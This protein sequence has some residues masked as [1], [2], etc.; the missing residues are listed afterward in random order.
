MA[1][2]EFARETRLVT[3]IHGWRS[4]VLRPLASDPLLRTAYS[5]MVNVAVAAGLG[6]LFWVATTRL[7]APS[8]VGRDA[9]VIAVMMEL[10]TICQLNF[11]NA[12]ARFLP[13]LE[14]GTMRALVGAYA[15]S[16]A[17]GVVLGT[18]FVLLAPT[19]SDQFGFF[20]D[21]WL[22]AALYVLAQVLWTWF[23][24]QD[25]ELPALQHILRSVLS[26]AS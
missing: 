11:V 9:A 25:V 16:G 3:P 26:A 24:L 6:L 14:R 1:Q 4:A 21:E 8:A 5:L 2:G 19:I 15:L 22:M 10:S 7:Y 20:G 13:T 23:V 12:L 18:A 17:A